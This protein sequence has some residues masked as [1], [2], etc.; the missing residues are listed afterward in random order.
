MN[1]AHSGHSFASIERDVEE[2]LQAGDGESSVR[3]MSFDHPLDARRPGARDLEAGRYG[4]LLVFDHHFRTHLAASARA[5]AKPSVG[6]SRTRALRHTCRHTATDR[7]QPSKA[8][9]PPP[10]TNTDHLAT[11]HNPHSTGALNTRFA[12]LRDVVPR[13]LC[14]T[15]PQVVIDIALRHSPGRYPTTLNNCRHSIAAQCFGK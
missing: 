4:P 2:E 3:S 14:D 13:S 12:V 1:V 7:L 9:V 8:C 5:E 10:R 11:H 15:C 6:C